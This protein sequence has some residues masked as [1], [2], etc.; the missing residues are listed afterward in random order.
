MRDKEYLLQ[1]IPFHAQGIL[2]HFNTT[3]EVEFYIFK[4]TALPLEK[5]NAG[6]AT[7]GTR[8]RTED[9]GENIPAFQ[10]VQSP[11]RCGRVRNVSTLSVES[12]G[13]QT[14]GRPDHSAAEGGEWL[15]GHSVDH[16]GPAGAAGAAAGCSGEG[17][18]LAL[19]AGWR[20][21]CG[22]G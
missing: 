18:A 5:S 16:R 6:L 17:Q 20:I 1:C 4:R 15:T 7:I 19:E 21:C 11:T 10:L 12:G 8:D 9:R 22:L 14:S 2:E 3:H 13:Y